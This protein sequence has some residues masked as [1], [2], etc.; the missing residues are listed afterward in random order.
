LRVSALVAAAGRGE[1]FGGDLPK[2]LAPLSGEPVL[3]RTLRALSDCDLVAEIIPLVAD[4]DGPVADFCRACAVERLQP[5]VLGGEHRQQSVLNGLEHLAAGPPDIVVIQDGARPLTTP[6]TIRQSI[7]LAAEH[8][9]AVAAVPMTD[10]VKRVDPSNHAVETLDRSNLR[11]VQTPQ[12]F[13]FHL[14]LQAHRTAAQDQF[15]ATDDAALV[16]RLGHPVRLFDSE[17]P[18]PKITAPEDLAVAEALL[19]SSSPGAPTRIGHGY[20][21]HRLAEGRRLILGGVKVPWE[22]GLEGHSDADV[23]T[24]AVCD[25]L[26]GALGAGDLGEHFPDT[27]PRYRDISSLDL[28]QHVARLIADQHLR[29]Q[30]LDATLVAQAPRLAPFRSQMEQNLA[31]SLG[32]STAHVNVKLTTTE[33]LGFCGRGEG[34]AAYAVALLVPV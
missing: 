23:L 31:R 5:P 17:G 8:G 33:G 2:L 11:R 29:L 9:S 3:A 20:D 25:A 10:T 1:R 12:T 4:L 26:L 16:E 22:R 6:D 34:M 7:L 24:H 18:N 21:V 27:D 13:G 19:S 14:I 30:H 15:R 28:A 32:V